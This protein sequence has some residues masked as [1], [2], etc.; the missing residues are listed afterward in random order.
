MAVFLALLGLV[1]LLKS[2]SSSQM[3]MMKLA[4]TSWEGMTITLVVGPPTRFLLFIGTEPRWVEPRPED[5]MHFMVLLSDGETGERI[6]YAAVWA[7]FTDEQGQ[8]VFDER[9]WP[10]IS[11]N[12]GTHYGT[13]VPLPEGR[14]TVQVQIGPPQAARHP[15]Y[16]DRWLEPFV[17]ETA[18]EW[19]GF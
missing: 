3:Q 5:T 11:Q 6:P 7:T 19:E 8:I 13:N 2:P 10:M 15:E 9:M 1:A 18:I 17:F 16:A 14:Y 12:M 4:E